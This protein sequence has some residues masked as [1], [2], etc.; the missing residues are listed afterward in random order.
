MCSPVLYRLTF[1]LHSFNPPR[2]SANLTASRELRPDGPLYFST[3]PAS[4]TPRPPSL[5]GSTKTRRGRCT[6]SGR[7]TFFAD[8]ARTPV[9]FNLV[10]LG[11]SNKARAIGSGFADCGLNHLLAVMELTAPSAWSKKG[12][13]GSESY[14]QHNHRQQLVS[15]WRSHSYIPALYPPLTSSFLRPPL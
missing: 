6:F 5:R 13:G 9:G 1:S 14:S 2:G 12:G 8:A 10:T 15:I 3:A 7:T 11:P 4:Y